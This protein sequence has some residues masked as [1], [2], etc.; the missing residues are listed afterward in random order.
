MKEAFREEA[1]GALCSGGAHPE[2]ESPDRGVG[3]IEFRPVRTEGVQASGETNA[4]GERERLDLIRTWMPHE[5]WP[6]RD[7]R[8]TAIDVENGSL[9]IWTANSYASLHQAVASSCAVPTLYP[10]VEIAGRRYIDGGVGSPTN[11]SVAVGFDLV[12]VIDPRG[13]VSPLAGEVEQL[14]ESGSRTLVL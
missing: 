4:Q 14:E 2:D 9:Q 1:I 6:K 11:A 3:E 10:P 5:G 13:G 8:I 7:L 12:I